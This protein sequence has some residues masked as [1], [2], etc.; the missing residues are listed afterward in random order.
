MTHTCT[1]ARVL[2]SLFSECQ[3]VFL[4]RF[5]SK[6]LGR[7][8]LPSKR[9]RDWETPFITHVLMITSHLFWIQVI[10][11]WIYDCTILEK[12]D[13]DTFPSDMYCI[14][15]YLFLVKKKKTFLWQKYFSYDWPL[16]SFATK[17]SFQCFI[18]LLLVYGW[19]LAGSAFIW[20]GKLS[21]NECDWWFVVVE[22]PACG[23]MLFF[24]IT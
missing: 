15:M 8:V 20:F 14:P 6:M 24:I 5:W 22:K 3:E 13:I 21:K 12:N 9:T 16:V 4:T 17:S 1:L 23:C 11:C 2:H 7:H 19:W 18:V 10:L